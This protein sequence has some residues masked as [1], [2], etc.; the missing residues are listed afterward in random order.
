MAE[1][2]LAAGHT[3]TVW[4]RT[5]A[6]A[7]AL[8][9]KGATSAA[10]PAAAARDA[11]AVV[12]MLADDTAVEEVTLGT[13]GI[14]S[15]MKQGAVH[16]SMSTISV[17]LSEGLTSQHA[18]HHTRYVSA[19]VWGRPDAARAAKLFVIA[20]GPDDAVR[21]VTP[22]FD[23]VGQRVFR[24]GTDP[25]VANLFK[26][27]GN[28]MIIAAIET[29]AEAFALVRKAGVD[30]KMFREVIT[31]SLFTAPLYL[32]YSDLLSREQDLPALF[33]A[34][35]GLKDMRLML[36]A[37][38]AL[39]VPMPIGG[40]LRDAYLTAFA[41]AYEDRDVTVLGRVAAENAG[42]DHRA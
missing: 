32:N 6:K 42:I 39:R 28:F 10:T 27:A 29:M 14:L 7:K 38:N 20:G 33:A 11:E 12:T 3:L 40:M 5:E 41:R 37:S 13:D 4:N 16:V 30:P 24:V 9:S 15:A 26:L 34:T 25:S 18:L 36:E 21:D 35:L 22:I 17:S 8:V 23:A 19:P 1:H 31:T 2:L